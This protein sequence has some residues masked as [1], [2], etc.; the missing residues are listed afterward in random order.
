ML[1]D[2]SHL[3]GASHEVVAVYGAAAE[4]QPRNPVATNWLF[5]TSTSLKALMSVSMHPLVLPCFPQEE[6]FGRLDV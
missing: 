5:N 3:V 1:A 6:K 4:S 2:M